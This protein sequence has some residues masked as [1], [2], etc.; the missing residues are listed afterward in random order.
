MTITVGIGEYAVTKQE[1]ASIKTY[2]LGSCVAL[3]LFD[4]RHGAAGMIHIALP[5]SQGNDEKAARL[6]GYFADTG[7]TL[8]WKRMQVHGAVTG[9]VR[10]KLVGG[11]AVFDDGGAF[12]I[13]RRN[14]LA[15]KKWL[16]S[17]G[18]GILGEEVGGNRSRTVEA[19]PD[20][21]VV[22]TSGREEQVI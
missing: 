3:I 10:A 19:Y 9:N 17:M 16:W 22:I 14:V 20:G 8:L 13:G 18:I 12:R 7:L 5:D 11:A 21:R 6:P 4:S 1:K 2:A 15:V